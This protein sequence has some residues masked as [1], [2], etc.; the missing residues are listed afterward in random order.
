[1]TTR[2]SAVFQGF[3]CYVALFLQ[4]TAQAGRRAAAV[5]S[6]SPRPGVVP[7]VAG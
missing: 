1:M 6:V 5:P 4:A 7:W 3:G 2:T